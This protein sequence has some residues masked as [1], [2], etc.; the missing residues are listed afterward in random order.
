M[1]IVPYPT[2]RYLPYYCLS[3]RHD[4]NSQTHSP[5]GVQTAMRTYRQARE[6]LNA[7]QDVTAEALHAAVRACEQEGMSIREAGDFIG[8][9][10]NAVARI[11]RGKTPDASG[12]ERT[13][14]PLWY[15]RKIYDLLVELAVNEAPGP[16]Y[17]TRPTT[18]DTN[19][20]NS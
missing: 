15:D 20:I 14:R 6:I 13:G 12:L 5:P 16:M 8:C 2:P 1:R 9:G 18:T 10:R 19:E 17:L 11:L 7:A 3:M 4:E